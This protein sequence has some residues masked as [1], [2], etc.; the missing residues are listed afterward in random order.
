MKR[1]GLVLFLLVGGFNASYG[2][3]YGVGLVNGKVIESYNIRLK[4]PLF[5]KPFV[6]VDDSLELDLDGVD[7]F[8]NH[9]GDYVVRNI[10][11]G[12]RKTILN[13]DINGSISLFYIITQTGGYYDPTFGYTRGREKITYYF[14]KERFVVQR[15]NFQ[16][17]YVAVQ[18][19]PK[20]LEKLM[21]AQ[22]IK[23]TNGILYAT[24]AGLLAAGILEQYNSQGSTNT[25]S[26]RFS[27]FILA[28]LIV[29]TIPQFRK[30][31]IHKKFIDAILIYN[32][33]K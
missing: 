29:F 3:Q 5:K 22:K 15:L 31:Q 16:N 13:R 6:L 7:Y 4:N 21:E 33:L 14:E 23:R 2:Q 25:S 10:T 17:L 30:G 19:Q 8:T 32:D 26:I 27:P 1:F 28:G 20:S 12:S 18:D 9:T 11:L 24:G